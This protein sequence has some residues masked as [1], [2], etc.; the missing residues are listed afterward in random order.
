MPEDRR[1]PRDGSQRVPVVRE[2][3]KVERRA[4][5]TAVVRVRK[6]VGWRAE[7]VDE[8]LTRDDVVVERVPIDRF[9]EALSEE[10]VVMKEA[11]VVEEVV[12]GKEVEERTETVRDKRRLETYEPE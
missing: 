12:V 5:P 10:P 2:G 1:G 11:R 7:I 3:V 4:R 6:R 8:P 9:V